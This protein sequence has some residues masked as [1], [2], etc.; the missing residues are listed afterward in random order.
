MEIGSL[1]DRV[2]VRWVRAAPFAWRS[3]GRDCRGGAEWCAHVDHRGAE[4][5]EP[6][7]PTVHNGRGRFFGRRASVEHQHELRHHGLLGSH[8][9]PACCSLAH[10]ALVCSETYMTPSWVIMSS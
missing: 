2:T 5:A 9:R 3:I 10:F 7:H 1:D 4:S 8:P 6:G